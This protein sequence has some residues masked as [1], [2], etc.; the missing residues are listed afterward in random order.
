MAVARIIV[1]AILGRPERTIR[2][3]CEVVGY[4]DQGRA[5]YDVAACGERLET[6]RTRERKKTRRHVSV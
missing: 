5:L 2:E 3:Y 6:V 4:D 1:A